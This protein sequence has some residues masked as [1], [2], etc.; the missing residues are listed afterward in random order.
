MIIAGSGLVIA[1]LTLA[2]SQRYHCRRD[3]RLRGQQDQRVEDHERRLLR[4]EHTRDGGR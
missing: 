4:L 2:L 3:D 1:L